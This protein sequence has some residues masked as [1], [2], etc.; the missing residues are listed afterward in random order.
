M[1]HDDVPEK[2]AAYSPD[3]TQIV[4]ESNRNGISEIWVSDADGSNER[5]LLPAS[6]WNAE[7]MPSDTEMVATRQVGDHAVLSMIDTA[8]GAIRD[9]DLGGLE[10]TFWQMPRPPDGQEI[11]FSANTKPG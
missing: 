11:I 7:F 9:L 8:T 2:Q 4:F 1:T 3:G 10:P 6:G 5:Q